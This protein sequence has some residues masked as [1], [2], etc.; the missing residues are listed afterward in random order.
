VGER[1]EGS[2]KGGN[3]GMKGE[4]R[5]KEEGQRQKYDGSN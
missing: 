5:N 4:R 2:N 3:N 1:S